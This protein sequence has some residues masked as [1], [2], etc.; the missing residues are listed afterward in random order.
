MKRNHV[1]YHC[2]ALSFVYR[3]LRDNDQLVGC[4]RFCKSRYSRRHYYFRGI[5]C[6]GRDRQRQKIQIAPTQGQYMCVW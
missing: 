5:V 4:F 6:S 2:G 3:D 1:E